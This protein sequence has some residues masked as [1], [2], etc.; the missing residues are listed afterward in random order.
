MTVNMEGALSDWSNLSGLSSKDFNRNR[1]YRRIL[2]AGN[3]LNEVLDHLEEITPVFDSDK[4]EVKTDCLKS[5]LKSDLEP[6]AKRLSETKRKKARVLQGDLLRRV[7]ALHYRC[8]V[9]RELK[10]VP[11]GLFDKLQELAVEWKEGEDLITDKSLSEQDLQCL[12]GLLVYP[13]LSEL[14]LEHQDMRNDFFRWA[15]R[16]KCS[17]DVWAQYPKLEQK[18]H[19]G[20]L[21]RRAGSVAHE[22]LGVRVEATSSEGLKKEPC[23]LI[24]KKWVP[25][26][27]PYRKVTFQGGLTCSIEE[28]FDTFRKKYHQR[29]NL[30]LCED[31]VIDWNSFEWGYWNEEKQEVDRIDLS[32][33]QWWE[34]LPVFETLTVDQVEG[35]YGIQLD[36]KEWGAV[37][38][39]SRLKTT[40]DALGHHG[41]IEI[42]M[43]T[44]SGKYQVFPLGKYPKDFPRSK[45]K[46][47]R[48][49]CGTV[50][51]A[52]TYPDDNVSYL[53]RQIKGFPIALAPE[54]GEKFMR[55]IGKDIQ[56]T[57]DDS[58]GFQ[59]LGENCATWGWERLNEVIEGEVRR[60]Y[61]LNIFETEPTGPSGRLMTFVRLF[62]KPLRPNMLNL[63]LRVLGAARTMV[64]SEGEK[65]LTQYPRFWEDKKIHFPSA[66]FV[67][68]LEDEPNIA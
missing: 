20:Y 42:L 66:L 21:D 57:W 38:M 1:N 55:N 28:I 23:L 22:V 50:S 30:E 13:E 40:L 67:N 41:W 37:L 14:I 60:I 16:Y 4:L 15:L 51:G 33:D 34:D 24:E 9:V 56:A 49:L 10:G 59:Y 5:F 58:F 47:M 65:S 2:D 7:Y 25:I 29:V 61:E 43:P 12:R 68:I 48:F 39:A 19:H 6:T 63:S 64:T 44:E 31:G 35:E 36:G 11:L 3:A 27:D 45:G 32:K 26:N 62:P 46:Q 8:Q 17:V 53:H 52:I 18:L 54:L